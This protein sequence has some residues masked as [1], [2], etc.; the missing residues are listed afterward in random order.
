MD[1]NTRQWLREALESFAFHEKE[2]LRRICEVLST[3]ET[4]TDPQELQLKEDILHELMSIIDNPELARN[5]VNSGGILHL[6]RCMLGSRY[7]SV[8]KMSAQIFSSA[9][10]NNPDVQRDAHGLGVLQGLME[11]LVQE[12]DVQTKEAYMSSL[13]ALVRGEFEDARQDFI[14]RNGLSF[15]H[16]II[17]TPISLRIVKR[18]LL[19]VINL[20]Y[21]DQLQPSLG[22]FDQAMSLGFVSTL[23]SMESHTDTEVR[24]MAIQA[25][26]NLSKKNVPASQP[27]QAGL[28][29]WRRRL[30]LQS[31]RSEELATIEEILRSRVS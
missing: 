28:E 10:Q 24:M 27:I 5:F 9:T 1:E 3:S 11:A 22:I 14:Q 6:V 25:L 2:K 26:H 13:S 31:D 23:M 19:L 18:S 16:D 29:A 17:L 15:I 21:Y 30:R 20:F 7:V 8:R 4:G 12:T